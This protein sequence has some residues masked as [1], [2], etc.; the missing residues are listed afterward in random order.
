MSSPSNSK[1]MDAAALHQKR[2]RYTWIACIFFAL[3]GLA[4][5]I[6]WIGW[7]RFHERTD[8]AYVNGNMIMLTPQVNGIVKM[9]L[10]DNAEL[11]DEGQPI[12][13]LDRHDY[14]I[15]LEKAEADLG[16]AVRTVVQFFA[17]VAEL[18]SSVDARKADLLRASLDYGHRKALVDEGGVSKEDFEHSETTLL[19]AYATLMETQQMLQGARAEIDGTTVATHPR[20][21]QAKASLK[22]AFLQLHRCTVLSP[23]RGILTQRRVQVGQYVAAEDPL[24]AIVPLEQIWVDANFREVQLKNFRLGQPVTMF[25]DMYGRRI[26]YHGTLVGLNPGT[27]SVFS[28]LPPQNATGNWIKIIQRVPVKVSLDSQEL[29]AH[30]LVLGLSMTVTVDT[31]SLSGLR[32][33]EQAPSKPLYETNVYDDELD[34]VDQLIEHIIA[35]NSSDDYDNS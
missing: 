10:S 26:E 9:I 34:G 12:V 13:E 5:F 30:P 18:E 35:E 33:P 2:K 25:S 31:H 19:S 28:I 7:G 1:E 6:Y 23:A 4:Y 32:L 21:E 3:C 15:A 8:D 14:E 20:V 27:G 16:D 29:K 17:K 11:V 24:L 22:T